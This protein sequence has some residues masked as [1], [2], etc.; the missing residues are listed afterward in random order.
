MDLEHRSNRQPNPSRPSAPFGPVAPKKLYLAKMRDGQCRQCLL[1]PS[2]DDVDDDPA[3]GLGASVGEAGAN[4][5]ADVRIVQ[6]RLNRVGSGHGG[7]ESPLDEDGQCGA[8][9]KAAILRFQRSHPDLLNDGRVDPGKNTWKKLVALSDGPVPV[10]GSPRPAQGAVKD[11]KASNKVDPATQQLLNAVLYLAR[12]RI[13]EAIKSLDVA[14]RELDSLRAL[15]SLDPRDRM[16]LWEAYDRREIDLDEL[17]TVDRVFHVVHRR[18][19]YAHVNDVIRRLRRIYVN[20]IEVIV[21]N[22]FVTTNNEATG[23]RRYLRVVPQK[24]LNAS[25]ARGAIADAPAGGWWD[26]NANVSH[27]RVGDAHLN[28]G[29]MLTTLI[30]EMSHFVSHH[31]TYFVGNHV[32]GSYNKAFNDTHAQSVRNAFCYEWYALLAAFKH[33]RSV[34]NGELELT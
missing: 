10:G 34:S 26:R 32:S 18:M 23:R 2:S 25:H 6:Q 12:W 11:S 13:Y 8:L 17:P 21:A 29:D 27:I 14:S 20:M 7:P 9:T 19:T 28:D 22:T 15:T 30:H 16:T 4:A 24:R 1:S 3:V 31:A 33:Q 5:S